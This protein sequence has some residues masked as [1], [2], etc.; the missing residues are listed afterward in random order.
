MLPIQL[1]MTVTLDENSTG[2]LAEFFQKTLGLDTEAV[3]RK[4]R[5][6]ASQ[7][8]LFKGNVPSD[9]ESSLLVDT[10]EAAKL[11]NLCGKTLYSMEKDERMPRSIK[12]GRAVR[13]NRE[14]LRAWVNAGCPSVDEWQWPARGQLE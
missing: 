14:E 8:A 1:K 2:T 3:A 12:I 11:L 10:R 6:E 7:H 5:I 9:E 13:W 4:R